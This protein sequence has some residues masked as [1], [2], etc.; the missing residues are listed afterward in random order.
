MLLNTTSVNSSQT[1]GVSLRETFRNRVKHQGILRKTI[2]LLVKK[3]K[4]N[5]I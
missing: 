4:F 3:N 1:A 2:K 5:K